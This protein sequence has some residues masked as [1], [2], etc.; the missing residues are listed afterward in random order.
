MQSKDG[1]LP[2]MAG[3]PDLYYR[4]WDPEDASRAVLIVIHGLAEHCGRYEAF[5]SYFTQHRY[6][7]V[8]LDL[9]GHGQSEGHCGHVDRFSDYTDAVRRLVDEVKNW[10]PKHPRVLVGHSMG[11][12][13]GTTFLIEHQAEFTAAVLSGPAIQSPI[14]PSPFLLF[15]NRIFSIVAPK[16]GQLKLDA[17]GVSRDPEVVRNYVEDPLVYT[18]KVSARQIAELFKAMD[19]LFPVASIIRLPILMLHGGEDSMTSVAGTQALYEAVNSPSKKLR[20]FDGLFHEIFNEPE[21]EQVLGEMQ[22]WIAQTL[23]ASRQAGPGR[24]RQ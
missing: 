8:A 20:I 24:R 21:R 3:A 1:T 2:Q 18:G 12:L 6:S 13:I 19:G 9:P 7:V 17:T 22:E 5:A 4:R 15:L 14:R 10:Y 23:A 16:M 11:G